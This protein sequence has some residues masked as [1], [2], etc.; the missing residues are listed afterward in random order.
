[1]QSRSGSKY[2]LNEE[3]RK[4]VESANHRL[5]DPNFIKKEFSS[6]Q[7]VTVGDFT[8]KVMEDIGAN[9]K[10]QIV[11]LKTKRS[12]GQFAHRDGSIQLENPAGCISQ[13]LIDAIKEILNSNRKGRIE[14]FGEEDLAVIPVI[15]FAEDGSVVTYGVPDRGLAYITVNKESR[16]RVKGIFERMVIYGQD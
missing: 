10:L 16:I 1:M 15:L 14:V 12:E 5:C 3:T 6:R 11:D 9:I 8:T 2:C 7:L 13:E 4:Q